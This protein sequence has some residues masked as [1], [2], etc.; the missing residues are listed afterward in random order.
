[1]NIFFLDKDPKLAAWWL[2]DKHATKMILETTQLISNAYHFTDQA[3]LISDIYKVAYAKHPSSKWVIQNVHNFSWL[4]TYLASLVD[5][6]DNHLSDG[7]KKNYARVRTILNSI[8]E[9]DPPNLA[10]LGKNV[11]TPPFLAFGSE[12]KELNKT[13]KKLQQQYGIWNEKL[14]VFESLT[15]ENGVE[16]YRKYYRLKQFKNN[17]FPEWKKCPEKCPSWWKTTNEP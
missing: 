6:Y 7:S 16:A 17:K 11:A 14:Q 2:C 5:Y 3:D 10:H 13:Y 12:D 4:I 15:W 9:N 8:L 1:M